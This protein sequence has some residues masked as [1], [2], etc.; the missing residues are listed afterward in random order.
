[1]LTDREACDCA[2]AVAE[3]LRAHTRRGPGVFT[4]LDEGNA[5]FDCAGEYGQRYLTHI[6]AAEQRAAAA[7]Q[8]AHW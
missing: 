4:L 6:W 1:M 2:L 5:S 3:Y 7:R 8:A